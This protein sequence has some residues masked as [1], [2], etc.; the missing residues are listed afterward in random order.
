M[1]QGVVGKAIGLDDN[2]NSIDVWGKDVILAYVPSASTGQEEPSYGYTYTMDGNPSVEVPYWD[3][4]TKSW[5][6]G[7]SYERAPVASGIASGFILNNA[8]V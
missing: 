1:D 8:V 2:D 6:Y 5:V 3:N 4:S 7:V